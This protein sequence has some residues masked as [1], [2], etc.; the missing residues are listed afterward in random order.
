MANEKTYVLCDRGGDLS[1]P[2]FIAWYEAGKR[3][4]KYGN[5]NKAKTV[6]GRKAAAAALIAEL[7]SLPEPVPEIA[8][9]KRIAAYLQSKRTE[10]RK[11]T[12]Q[13]YQSK[14]DTFTL[15][16]GGRELS[17]EVVAAFLDHVA[18]SR[19][20]ATYN[21]YVSF[22][23]TIFKRVGAPEL[24]PAAEVK[25]AHSTPALYFQ[26]YQVQRLK[27]YMLKHDPE[28]WQFCQFVY[29][30]F[31][32]PGELRLLKVEDV[33][34]D[35]WKIRVPA[36][37]SKNRKMQVVTIPV[38]F[39]PDLEGLRDRTPGA[40]LFHQAGMPGTPYNLNRMNKRHRK[41]LTEL[42]FSTAHKLYSWKHTG[43]INAVLAGVTVKELQ[44]QLRHASLEEVD[45]YLRQLGAFDLKA[46][47]DKFPGI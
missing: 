47:E 27:A 39:R 7:Q 42:G 6:A 30:C 2:W 17:C 25:R 10:W 32:R 8:V 35:E 22:F 24:M 11:K 14:L 33:L 1:K 26:R 34:L 4:R 37:V 16:L 18:A 38:A 21:W 41:V 9:L 3:I 46:L 15:W 44:I 43:A 13:T 12:F 23:R 20:P 19:K 45:K 29:Y 28:M 36:T 5:I 40:Y 31:I